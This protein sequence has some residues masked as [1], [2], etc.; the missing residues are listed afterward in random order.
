MSL[1]VVKNCWQL[2]CIQIVLSELCKNIGY[3]F[4]K[5]LVFVIY[6]NMYIFGCS[7]AYLFFVVSVLW[8]VC[9]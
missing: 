8:C 2:V 4:R 7:L 9:Y 1:K 3:Q 6:G 5:D